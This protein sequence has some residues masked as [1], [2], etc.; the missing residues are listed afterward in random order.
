MKK[1]LS[2]IVITL[3]FSSCQEDVKF[4]TPGFQGLKDDVFWRAND[5]RAYI[6]SN[7]TLTIKGLTEFE[8][9]DLKTNYTAVGTYLLG[10]PNPFNK[11]IYTSS[12]NDIDL[13]YETTVV[14]GPVFGVTIINSGT[15]YTS[16]SSIATTGGTGSGLTVTITANSSGVVTKVLVASGGNGYVSG[17]TITVTGGNLNCRIRVVNGGEIKITEYD[18]IN[19]T[20]S[21]TF[22]INAT[23]VNNNPAG[24]PIL[25]FQYGAFYKVPIYPNL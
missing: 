6:A 4:N 7:G 23:N 16:G 14:P 3:L 24:G 21:G 20:V 17:D 2:L 11:A 12:L 15:G 18:T 9:L 8:E 5:A 10:T 25:N 1:F 19:Q 22:K 13:L